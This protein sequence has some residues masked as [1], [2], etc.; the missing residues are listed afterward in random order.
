VVLMQGFTVVK[1][2]PISTHVLSQN[3]I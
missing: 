1:K 3:K 2:K